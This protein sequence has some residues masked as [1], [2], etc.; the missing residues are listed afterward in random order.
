MTRKGGD[1]LS[2]HFSKPEDASYYVLNRSDL[3][4][5]F[6][7]AEYTA[8]PGKETTRENRVQP[9]TDEA[10]SEP[11]EDNR[12]EKNDDASADE[13]KESDAVGGATEDEDQMTRNGRCLNYNHGRPNVPVRFCCMCGE[14]VNKNIS[15]EVCSE[16]KHTKEQ[17]KGNRYCVDCGEQLNQ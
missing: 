17:S 14:V 5:Y 2:Y 1:V 4:H 15:A 8:D 13:G 16:E 12:D 3:D 7:V 10:S 11:P 6:K 9:R